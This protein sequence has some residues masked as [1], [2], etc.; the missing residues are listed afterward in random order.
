MA[1]GPICEICARDKYDA[2]TR[3]LGGWRL[4][5]PSGKFGAL[6]VSSGVVLFVEAGQRPLRD[7]PG[8]EVGLAQ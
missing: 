5:V 1:R 7:G 2:T 4:G 3:F 8:A 6:R